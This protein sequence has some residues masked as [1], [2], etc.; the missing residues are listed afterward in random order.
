VFLLWRLS[1]IDMRMNRRL[2]VTFAAISPRIF[3][4]WTQFRGG[5]GS[6]VSDG[7]SL[8][9][10]LEK[11]VWR[12]SL[13]MGKSSP[14]I[15]GDRI[16]VTAAEEKT[17]LTVA[18]E[19]RTGREVWRRQIPASRSEHLHQLNFPASATPVTDGRHVWVFF[20]DFGL[21]CFRVSGEERWRL[22]IGPFN[23][24][25]G[26]GA[27]PVL[28]RGKIL[29]LCD[30]D[31]NAF[32]VAVD[33]ESGKIAWKVDRS[34]V[35]H[36][37]ST[38]V[39]W[40]DQVIAPGSYQMTAYSIAT[41]EKLWWVRGLTWQPKS[42]PIIGRAGG[43]EVLFF[44]G[45][46]PGG[47]AGQQ[48]ELPE[49]RVVVKQ[50]DTDR[51]GRL[52]NSELN[53]K[54]WRPTGTWEAVDLD[55]DGFLDSRD[56]SFFK[57]RRSA[58]NSMMAVK[59]GGKGDVTS[60]HVLWRFEKNQPDVPAPLLY[61]DALYLIKNGAILTILDAATGTLLKQDR[62]RDAPGEYYASPVAGD[63]KAYF[64]SREGKISVLETKSPWNV[65]SVNDMGDELF[66]TPALHDGR[67][68][69]RS[70]SALSCFGV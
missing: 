70:N 10:M 41:G 25:H 24:L 62:L 19:R 44:N 1:Y 23:N 28:A 55:N 39:V 2:F 40:G 33:A 37:F 50:C 13:P 66:A 45:W 29:M 57:A 16:Y 56:W 68:Y 14:V 36:G 5:A 58:R 35:Q 30:Q 3:A 67:I 4:D 52:S 18:V 48:Y 15:A 34:E 47:D 38:P 7:T 65:L 64:S 11:P 27:S 26:M 12:T 9:A 61:R 53:V 59:L 43:E 51:D 20:G 21:A 60:S 49:F 8:P 22:P 46:A 54:E 42:V 17:L 69:V 6:G 63:G 31:T 32:L